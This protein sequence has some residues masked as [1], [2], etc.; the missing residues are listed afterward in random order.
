[1]QCNRT[2][3]IYN[4]RYYRN[5]NGNGNLLH[6]LCVAHSH[7]SIAIASALTKMTFRIVFFILSF[8]W[9]FRIIVYRYLPIYCLRLI[10]SAWNNRIIR[11]KVFTQPNINTDSLFSELCMCVC[12]YTSGRWLWTM[13]ITHHH[14]FCEINYWECVRERMRFTSSNYWTV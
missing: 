4:F 12:V 13:S 7:H 8:S 3:F 10:F 2:T 11:L 1:M 6:A 14:C 5:R 9:H